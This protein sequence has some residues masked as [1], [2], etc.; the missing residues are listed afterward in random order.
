[1]TR[2]LLASS[3]TDTLGAKN[4]KALTLNTFSFV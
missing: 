4:E 1:M 2:I 3:G